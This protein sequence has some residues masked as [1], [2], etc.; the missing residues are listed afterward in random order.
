MADTEWSDIKRVTHAEHGLMV[1]Q[2]EDRLL[3]QHFRGERQEPSSGVSIIR[4]S[5]R[6]G[7]REQVRLVE[8]AGIPFFQEKGIGSRLA[9]TAFAAVP[10]RSVTGL[11]VYGI[12]AV[13]P[14]STGIA[15]PLT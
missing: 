12:D 5:R 9:R 15:W 2:I 1:G 4:P 10:A 6:T 3:A 11:P 13:R 8:R 7:A 14:P